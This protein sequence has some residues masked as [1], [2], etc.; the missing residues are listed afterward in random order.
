MI[1]CFTSALQSGHGMPGASQR[2]ARGLVPS[3][4]RSSWTSHTQWAS[5][6]AGHLI[7]TVYRLSLHP[8]ICAFQHNITTL[9]GCFGTAMT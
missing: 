2:Q 6:Q 7:I 9:S 4:G 8:S 3:H 1:V 5:S